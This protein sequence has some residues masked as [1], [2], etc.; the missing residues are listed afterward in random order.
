MAER[1]DPLRKSTSTM[2]TKTYR[3]MKDL[4]W[5]GEFPCKAHARSLPAQKR[6]TPL[7]QKHRTAEQSLIAN[8]NRIASHKCGGVRGLEGSRVSAIADRQRK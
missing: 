8:A 5:A 6:L 2:A 3:G 4:T 7:P 1:V